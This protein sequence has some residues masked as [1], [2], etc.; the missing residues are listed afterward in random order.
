MI[1]TILL[2][3]YAKE[4]DE[5]RPRG[6]AAAAVDSNVPAVAA[7]LLAFDFEAEIEWLL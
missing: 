3:K 1:G 2:L 6:G 5:L 7:K 4:I